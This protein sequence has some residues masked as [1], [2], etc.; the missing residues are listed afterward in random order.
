MKKGYG[1]ANLLVIPLLYTSQV[2]FG[3]YL[4]SYC[5]FMLRRDDYFNVSSSEIGV[6]ASNVLF[7]QVLAQMISSIFIGYVF[8]LAGRKI[9][10]AVSFVL[11]VI[12]LAAM[13]YTAPS[14]GLLIFTRILV[15]IALSIQ[16][17]NPLLIDYVTKE[18]RGKATVLQNGGFILGQLL[19]MGLLF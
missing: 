2:M 9:T 14:L 8:D 19:G 3:A 10:I 13:P 15:G 12:A 1:L 11:F 16:L 5:I 4:N 17:G 6:V 7:W 18:C